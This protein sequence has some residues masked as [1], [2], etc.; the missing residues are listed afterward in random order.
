M[1]IPIENIYY[2]LCYAWNKLEAKEQA[3]IA[4][5]DSTE[6]IELFTRM[7]IKG[8]K[9]LLKRGIE[10]NYI[11]ETI[12]YQGVKGKLELSP[13]IKS[14]LHLYQRT[15]C[16][17]DKFSENIVIN[18][19]LF[20]TLLRL[21]H[22]RGLDKSFIAEIKVLL[23]K[24]SGIEPVTLSN[25]IFNDVRLHRNNHH[26]GVLLHVCKMLYDNSLPTEKSG[27]WIFM[28]FTRDERQMNRL[29][30]AFLLNFYRT[31]LKTCEVKSE[32]IS[33][34]FH[35][36]DKGH[37]TFL[38][39]MLTDISIQTPDVKIIIDAKYYRETLASYYEKEKIK[40]ENLYQLF[41][42]LMNQQSEDPDSLKTKGILLYPTTQKEL[43]LS[44]MFEQHPIQIRTVNLNTHWKNIEYRLKRIVLA[45]K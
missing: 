7:L 27:E 35:A 1:Q 4:V 29:F 23:S 32:Q 14:G 41:S 8:T 9:R 30:E 42:Y 26:Y 10:R 19:I 25:R 15:I 22:T 39:R 24:L 37:L 2:L 12:D 3:K 45:E 5:D 17:V 40:S 13:T 43:D 31:E 34:Q 36:S 16:T 6:M 11:P 18:R 20:T 44:F 33:W 38:P 21:L 28:D